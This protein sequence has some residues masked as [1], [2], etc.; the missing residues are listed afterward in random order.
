MLYDFHTHT[1]LSD[2]ALSPIELIRRALVK[3]CTAIGLTDHVGIGSL[4]RIITELREDCALAQAYW[5]ILAIP[6]VE[7]THLPPQAITEAAHKAKELGAKLVIVHGETTMEPVEKGTNLTAVQSPHVDILAHP[8]LITPEEAFL[9]AQ[10]SI[11]LELTS[12]Q[13]HCLNNSHIAT[14]AQKT[15]ALLLVNSD[16][17]TERDLLTTSITE[18]IASAAGLTEQQRHQALIQNPLL[19]I[20]KISKT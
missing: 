13:G 1:F 18:S 5:G 17:H 7:L 19:L 6:G 16:A 3:G 4:Q 15:A 8:G 12:R 11:F 20:E 10:N 14:I 9:A 2:G